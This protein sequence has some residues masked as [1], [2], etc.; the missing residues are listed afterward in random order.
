MTEVSNLEKRI[1]DAF[2]VFD[3]AKM[4]KVDVRDLGTIVRALGIQLNFIKN[5][6]HIV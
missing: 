3:S 4:G 6:Q 5:H 2:N 1:T